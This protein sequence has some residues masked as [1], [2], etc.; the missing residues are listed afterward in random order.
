[1]TS[2]TNKY[3]GEVCKKSEAV[4]S[5]LGKAAIK[6]VGM[7]LAVFPLW[8]NEKKPMT[9]DGLYAATT[10]TDQIVSWWKKNPTANIGIA[11]ICRQV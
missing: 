6:Y 5:D 1:M 7:G 9:K 2:S 11:C 10:D 4:L 3:D 8:P